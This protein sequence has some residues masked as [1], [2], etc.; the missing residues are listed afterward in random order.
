M[1]RVLIGKF[2]VNLPPHAQLRLALHLH[3]CA[4]LPNFFLSS[5]IH[6]IIRFILDI[7][8]LYLGMV[9]SKFLTIANSRKNFKGGTIG[10]ALLAK[11]S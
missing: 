4:V 8:S 5:D 3:P 1:L 11:S 9:L 7:Q 10:T 2:L 6:A